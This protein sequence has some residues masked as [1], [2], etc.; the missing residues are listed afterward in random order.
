MIHSP[1]PHTPPYTICFHGTRCDNHMVLKP[2]LRP[3][4]GILVAIRILSG[5]FQEVL[6]FG[7]LPEMLVHSSKVD[8][9]VDILHQTPKGC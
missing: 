7:P 3:A 2:K 4:V 1:Q 9:S 5:E 6:T 8:P